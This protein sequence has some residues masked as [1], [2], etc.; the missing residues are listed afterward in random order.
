MDVIF[1]NDDVNKKRAVY[2]P[3]FRRLSLEDT[4]SE[5]LPRANLS[6]T[7]VIKNF[8]SSLIL[9]KAMVRE[10]DVERVA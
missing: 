2:L 5:T 3:L 7:E 9:E 6:A 10:R 8:I 4:E 1:S